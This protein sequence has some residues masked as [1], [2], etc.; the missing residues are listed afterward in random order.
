MVASSLTLGELLEGMCC[1]LGWQPFPIPDH[2]LCEEILPSVQSNPPLMQTPALSS[3]FTPHALLPAPRG[4]LLLQKPL[5]SACCLS[6]HFSLPPAIW[7]A[8]GL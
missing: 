7:Q 3:G 2:P 4:S 5:V 6:L 1:A 8:S